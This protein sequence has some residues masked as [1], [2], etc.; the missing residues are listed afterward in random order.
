MANTEQIKSP[1]VNS[2]Y[3]VL[4]SGIRV[5]DNEYPSSD[6]PAALSEQKFWNNVISNWSPHEPPVVISP[7][8]TR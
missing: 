8:K 7:L 4:R 6:D 5:S 3:V 1:D 2:S